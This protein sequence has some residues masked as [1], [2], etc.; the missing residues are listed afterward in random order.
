M[1][2]TISTRWFTYFDRSPVS[3]DNAYEV[4]VAWPEM[5]VVLDPLRDDDV[6]PAADEVEPGVVLPVVADGCATSAAIVAF[7][8][9]NSL[10][11][12][13]AVVVAV[14]RITQPTSVTS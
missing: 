2:P 6:E 9:M 4:P 5:P 8:R 7:D 1:R 14:G 10:P 11:P 3:P 13:L 12:A